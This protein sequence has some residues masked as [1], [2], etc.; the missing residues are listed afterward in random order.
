MM[1]A[2]GKSPDG[3]YMENTHDISNKLVGEVGILFTCK[4]KKEVEEWFSNY[5]EHDFAKSGSKATSTV[6][7]EQGPLTQFSHA[8]E[9]H[10]RK[11]GMPVAL[12]KG[13][14]T[15][16]EEYTVC[17]EG[18]TLNP[19]QANILKL[20]NVAM[21]EFKI[22]L[23]YCWEKSTKKFSELGKNTAEK[24]FNKITVAGDDLKYGFIEADAT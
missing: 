23:G 22:E 14:V 5:S 21:A 10:L 1:I 4:S 8:I 15:V 18:D 2:L 6:I 16:L 9:P 24:A 11:L 13:V 20:L 7:L 19:E 3:E 12:K 17:K